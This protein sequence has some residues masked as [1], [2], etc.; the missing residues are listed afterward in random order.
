MKTIKKILLFMLV[1]SIILLPCI[2]S[3][4][5]KDVTQSK[6]QDMEDIITNMKQN[7]KCGYK[8]LLVSY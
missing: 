8:K 4:E 5:S 2:V 1:T 3:A 7:T 6:F